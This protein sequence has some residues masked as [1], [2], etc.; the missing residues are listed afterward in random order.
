MRP[1]DL[2]ITDRAHARAFSLCGALVVLAALLGAFVPPAAAQEHP[3]RRVANIVGVAVEEYGKA[4]DEHGRL[5]SSTEFQ[6]ATD[7]LADAKLVAERLAGARAATAR[8]V[9]DSLTVAVAAK[10]PPS[11][12]AALN[13]RFALALGDEGALEMPRAALDLAQVMHLFE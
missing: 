8:Q 1:T 12:V 10:R 2:A 4:V 9:L 3:A 11:E 13:K 6:E 7:F 5:I